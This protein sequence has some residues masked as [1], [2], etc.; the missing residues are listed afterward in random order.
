MVEWLRKLWVRRKAVSTIIAGIIILTLFLSA[1]TAMV[2]VSQQYDLYQGTADK[3]SQK[4]VDALSENMTALYPGMTQVDCGSCTLSQYD[5]FMS[6]LGGVGIQIAEIYI[7]STLGGT[8]GCTIQNSNATGPCV[9]KPSQTPAA[10]VFNTNDAYL[11]AGEFN[12]TVRFWLPFTLPD[13]GLQGPSTPATT[14]WIATTRGRVFTF[15]W[16]FAANPLAIPGF[17]PNI[18][19]GDTK[20]AYVGS[21]YNSKDAS[22]NSLDCHKEGYQPAGSGLPGPGAPY[23][24]TFYFVNPWVVHD[25]LQKASKGNGADRITDLYAFLN[26]TTGKTL[27]L[28]SGSVILQSATSGPNAKEY[29]IGGTYLVNVTQ[30]TPQLRPGLRALRP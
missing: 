10:F 14:I 2:L 26:N 21:T 24:S 4:N 11:N 23:P 13:Q 18:I 19:R 27:K 7:D 22:T 16:P 30:P 8:T 28:V 1:L 9:L 29:F 6:N 3:M 20:I 12:H 15:L 25:L 5:L 17:T